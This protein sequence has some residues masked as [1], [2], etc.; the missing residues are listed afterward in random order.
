ML[1]GPLGVYDLIGIDTSFYA[2]R[3]LWD[4]FRDRIVP[5]PILP[6]LFK[7]GRLGQKKGVGF[8]VYSEQPSPPRID[9]DLA[10][11]VEPYVRSR[12][13]FNPQQLTTRLILPML[14]E[15]TRAIEEGIVPR[16]AGRRSG[17]DS[18]SGLPRRQGR[19]PVLG[20]LPGR[21]DDPRNA[22]A[23]GLSRPPRA[24]PALLIEMAE[25]G[26]TFYA[27]EH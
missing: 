26:R 1:L 15:A 17:G 22:R 12:K 10:R 5:S 24:P 20:R 18:W 19:T 2:G 27:A 4:A 16:S 23:L 7:A 9:P 8:Y 14:L 6:A 13:H 3:S 11:L 25:H 21:R